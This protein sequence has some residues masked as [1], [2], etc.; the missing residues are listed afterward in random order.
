LHRRKSYSRTMIANLILQCQKKR[1]ASP[2]V[3]LPI[4]GSTSDSAFNEPPTEQRE[5]RSSAMQELLVKSAALK[6]S[7]QRVR[8]RK[9]R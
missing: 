7:H 4:R 2:Q 8:K 5:H 6:R 1:R 3:I 9:V